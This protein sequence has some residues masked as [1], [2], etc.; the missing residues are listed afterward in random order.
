M[1]PVNLFLLLALWSCEN[2]KD[3]TANDPFYES[4][5]LHGRLM[6]TDEISGDIRK[7]LGKKT[8]YVFNAA[9]KGDGDF[10]LNTMTNEEGYFRFDNLRQGKS[11]KMIYSEALD[12][13]IFKAE[14]LTTTLPKDSLLFEATVSKQQ[15]G[16]I[17]EVTDTAGRP[18]GNVDVCIA[19]SE[20]PYLAGVCEGSNYTLK[21]NSRGK[22]GQFNMAEGKYYVL[23]RITINN[24][25]YTAGTEIVISKDKTVEKTLVMQSSV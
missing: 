25:K 3:L 7:P 15:P 20:L 9:D 5:Y 23:A 18:L 8:I 6:L 14:Y 10:I 24:V 11:F 13:K 21:T 4:S 22:A 12:G 17:L 16:V 19:S 1:K 2:Y